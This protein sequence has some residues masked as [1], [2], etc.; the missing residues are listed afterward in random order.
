MVD[1]EHLTP[2]AEGAV[3]H[4]LGK[5]PEAL[6]RVEGGTL[7]WNFRVVTGGRDFALRCHRDN[8]ESERILGEHALLAWAAAR[9]IA[10]PVAIPSRSGPTLVEA[11]GHRWSFALWL[12]GAHVPR[13]ILSS[14]QAWALG[15]M[16]GRIQ[17][18][19]ATHPDSLD[20]GLTLRWDID[21]SKRTLGRLIG[22]ASE[23]GE[24]PWIV[25]ALARQRD[26]LGAMTPL[27]PEDITTL[28]RQLVHGDFHDQQVLFEGDE[29]WAVLDWE[30]W[31]TDPRAWEL[32]RS[33]SF[34]KVM[35][36]PRLEDYLRGYHEHIRLG[37]DE[38]R[39]ALRLWFQSRIAGTW[40]WS[41]CFVEGNDRVRDF[42][43]D[44]VAELDRITTPGWTE[45]IADR[46]VRA[47]CN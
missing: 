32:V 10:V 24:E 21:E 38:A 16:H 2:L 14:A 45:G 1:W 22:V 23:R 27:T 9:G 34:S 42:F 46:L 36:S 15:E 41:A 47:A 30:I 37:E 25:E 13:G 3:R 7:N 43:P 5:S 12:P 20:A 39:L 4:W 35:D 11:D 28:P 33:L 6:V 8:L 19:L 26:L 44:M 17:T 18:H 29:V 31:R 40:A